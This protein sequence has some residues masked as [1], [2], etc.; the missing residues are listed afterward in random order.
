M[1]ED[2]VSGFGFFVFLVGFFVFR[3]FEI[4]WILSYG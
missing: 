2:G 3:F 1:I 4:W